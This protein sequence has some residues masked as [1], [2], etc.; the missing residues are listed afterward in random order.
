MAAIVRGIHSVKI[1]T[2]MTRN[3]IVAII[4]IYED[5][6]LGGP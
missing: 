5:W 2:N 1:T 4:I 3:M 6:L